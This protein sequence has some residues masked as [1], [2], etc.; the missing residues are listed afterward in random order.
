MHLVKFNKTAL[1]LILLYAFVSNAQTTDNYPVQT[2]VYFGAPTSQRLSEWFTSDQRLFVQLLLKDLTK[3]SV[4]VYLRWQLDGPGIRI[5]TRPG[6]MP[7]AFISLTPGLPSRLNGTDLAAHYFSPSLLETEGLDPGQAYNASLPE[8]FYTFSVQAFEASTG[9]VVSNTAQTFLVLSSLQPPLL[10]LPANGTS[11][12]VNA[13]QKVLFQWTPRHF[14]TP[15]S[16]VVYRLKVCRVPDQEEPN[17]QMMLSCT[18]PVLDKTDPGTSLTGNMTQWIQPLEAGQRYAVQVQAIDLTNQLTNFANQGYSQ[19]QWFRYGR[20]CLPPSSFTLQ[21]VASDRVRLRWEAPPQALAYVVEYK[22]ETATEWISEK[23]YGTT[24]MATG[25]QNKTTYLFRIRSDCGSL[26]PSAPGEEQAWN[27]SE[28]VP[29]PAPEWPLELLQPELIN[30]QTVDNEAVP[31]TTLQ[32]L[33]VNYPV[34]APNAVTPTSGG[35]SANSTNGLLATK[36]KIPDCALRAGSFVDCQPTHP[37]IPLPTGEE[38]TSLSVGDVLGIYDFA[39]IVTKTGEGPGFSG[40]GLVR[41]PFLGNA[42]MPMEFKGVKAKK[43]E[44]GTNGGCVYAIDAGGYVQSRNN[45][46]VKELMEQRQSLI[47]SVV[48]KSHPTAFVGTLQQALQRYDPVAGEM[49]EAK[50]AGQPATPEQ[51]QQLIQ[52][53]AAI[54]QGSEVLKTQLEKLRVI[55]SL[56]VNVLADLETLTDELTENQIT[57]GNGT[58]VPVIDGLEVK[59]QALFERLKQLTASPLELPTETPTARIAN[60]S[61]SSVEAQSAKIVWAAGKTFAKYTVLYAAEG[62]GELTQTVT[63]PQLALKNLKP[64]RNYTYK[65]VGYSEKGEVVDTYGTGIF[66]TPANILPPPENVAYIVQA[67]GSVKINWKKNSLHQSFKLIYKDVSGEERTLYPTTNSA[68]LSGL[69]PDQ[70]YAYSITAFGTTGNENLVSQAADG[71]FNYGTVCDARITASAVRILE[72][73]S[74]T[75]SVNSCVDKNGQ[76]GSVV[77]KA[78]GVPIGSFTGQTFT[79][80][81][82]TTYTAICQLSDS[83]AKAVS[84]SDSKEIMVDR[85]CTGVVATVAPNLIDRGQAVILRATGCSNKVEWRDNYPN[86]AVA[87]TG[88][89]VILYP[90]APQTYSLSCVDR[91]GNACILRAGDVTLKCG[92]QLAVTTTNVY[93]NEGWGIKTN[94]GVAKVIATGCN[95]KVVW[96]REGGKGG[97]KGIQTEETGDNTIQFSNITAGFTVT[98]TCLATN[99]TASA[100]IN[101]APT[102]G[103]CESGGNSDGESTIKIIKETDQTLTLQ[104]ADN[105]DRYFKWEDDPSSGNTRILSIPKSPTAFSVTSDDHCKKSIIYYPKASGILSIPCANFTL[106]APATVVIPYNQTSKSLTISMTG[107]T[108]PDP[109]VILWTWADATGQTITSGT[110]TSAVITVKDADKDKTFTFTATCALPGRAVDDTKTAKVKITKE[111]A[112]APVAEVNKQP[113]DAVFYT[114]YSQYYDTFL[115][116]EPVEIYVWGRGNNVTALISDDKNRIVQGGAI[117][118]YPDANTAKIVINHGFGLTATGSPT[119]KG[120]FYVEITN[121]VQGKGSCTGR[122]LITVDNNRSTNPYY[123]EYTPAPKTNKTTSDCSIYANAKEAELPIYRG[124]RDRSIYKIK[125][126][127]SQTDFGIISIYPPE[128]TTFGVKY[129]PPFRIGLVDKACMANNGAIEWYRDAGRTDRMAVG[130][131]GNLPCAIED[132]PNYENPVTYYGRCAYGNGKYC[133][134]ALRVTPALNSNGRVGTTNEE[135]ATQANCVYSTKAAVALLLSDILCNKLSAYPGSSTE[136]LEGLKSTFE[137]NDIYLAEITPQMIADLDAGNCAPV[138]AA[139]VNDIADFQ[140]VDFLNGL[141]S[142]ADEMTGNVLAGVDE[143]RTGEL[144]TWLKTHSEN[145]GKNNVEFKK[146]AFRIS[147]SAVASGF[148]YNGQTFSVYAEIGDDGTVDLTQTSTGLYQGYGVQIKHG[149]PCHTQFYLTVRYAGSTQNAITLWVDSF[150]AFEALLG[151][152]GLQLTAGGK[153]VFVNSYLSQ[154]T[155]AGNDCNRLDVIYENIPPF[156]LQALAKEMVFAHLK[157]IARCAIGNVGAIC[158]TDEAKAVLNMLK[159]ISDK[160]YLYDSFKANPEVVVNLYDKMQGEASDQYVSALAELANEY[161]TAAE[162]NT[163][164][165]VVLGDVPA[166]IAYTPVAGAKYILGTHYQD[167]TVYFENCYGRYNWSVFRLGTYQNLGPIQTFSA[168]LFDPIKVQYDGNEFALTYPAI[169]AWHLAWKQNK[170]TLLPSLLNNLNFLGLSSSAK[171]LLT[172]GVGKYIKVLAAIEISKTI[173]DAAINDPKVKTKLEAQH[174][175]FMRV[176]PY[177]SLGLDISTISVEHMLSFMKS[178]KAVAELLR[179]EGKEEAAGKLEELEAFVDYS[180]ELNDALRI[181]R[182]K[183]TKCGCGDELTDGLVDRIKN[184]L[185]NDEI[186]VLDRDLTNNIELRSILNLEPEL[187]EVWKGSKDILVEIIRIKRISKEARIKELGLDPIKNKVDIYEG[188]IGQFVEGKFGYFKRYTTSAEGD[189]VSL[190][191]QFKGRVFDAFGLPSNVT[192]YPNYDISKFFPSIDKHF[193]NKPNVDYLLLDMRY[194][195]S[196][197]KES[198]NKYISDNFHN[199]LNKL[200][201]LE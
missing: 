63:N 155:A 112:P 173:L 88:S 43:G 24:Y 143:L 17:E 158:N 11:V 186:V 154:L 148:E 144:F 48:R 195:N 98:A 187:V 101:R 22:A 120:S 190:S 197:Q 39:L 54:L 77:W 156:V 57:I 123:T 166:D 44:E 66:A 74:V 51:V 175:D 135:A 30:V 75:L 126:E 121:W 13:L 165:F 153:T 71:D 7:P 149:G 84:C 53:T 119:F 27:I 92:L 145:G 4:S 177:V 130:N 93:S 67:D 94:R 160:Q 87:G 86:G 164:R 60:V 59:Y 192:N 111:A 138:V 176:W 161:W 188:E 102:N 178:R 61:V 171:L 167:G 129:P 6:Y 68:L 16:Q 114:K 106:N 131:Y 26:L 170:E 33:Y 76:P 3:P 168:G 23:V 110:G 100:F 139:L 28:Q 21:S 46:S 137:D 122:I 116:S 163:N 55:N 18:E 15:E 200:F 73:E 191:G 82:T 85:K 146:S 198:V 62:D 78:N 182:S 179:R 109:G 185:S 34:Q 58:E 2:T 50:A 96:E 104:I 133:E 194:M 196:Q 29:E 128:Q 103:K 141:L 113:C 40:E 47:Q 72:G 172:R 64:G 125:Y 10:N 118:T 127:S 35:S 70:T 41:L 49:S 90:D 38:L 99:C 193:F 162:K 147:G 189:F 201:K 83:N 91:T 134:T 79:P 150:E 65:I 174:P 25:L 14:A 5:A 69:A 12:P 180:D 159:G 199:Q 32:E 97:I 105:N 169:V 107:C 152:L 132:K 45:V 136:K 36:L 183:F 124:S 140:D 95:G 20:E 184:N 1:L 142:G 19:V 37:V 52:S 9:Q 81:S 181:T 151:R 56:A 157:Q 80:S 31:L 8:G 108:N 115:E 42:M 89:T 117:I